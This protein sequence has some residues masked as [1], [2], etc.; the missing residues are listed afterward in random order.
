MHRRDFLL[1]SGTALASLFGRTAT[2]FSLPPVSGRL[3]T[4][5]GP[6]E[7]EAFGSALC[8]EHVLVDFI[9]AD[10]ITP[11]RYDANEVYQVALPY[12]RRAHELGCRGL[13]ECTPAYLGRDVRLLQRL[14]RESGLHLLTNT[15][16]YG[17]A[18]DQYVP[19]HAYDESAD[20]LASRWAA[21]WENGIEGTGIRPGFIKTGVD[22]GPL[23][24]IDRKLI[25]AAART[26]ARTGLAIASHTGDTRAALEQIEV[27]A[28][29]R[30]RHDAFIWVHAQNDWQAESRIEAARK[31]VWIEI[32]N[33]APP[34][35]A[36]CVARAVE[37]KARGLLGRLLVSHDAGWYSPGEPHGGQFRGFDA[38]YTALVPALRRAGFANDEVRRLLVSNPAEAFAVRPVR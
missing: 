2:A 32:D 21:E 16:Y 20:D 12:L 28:S 9:G 38:I 34:S 30:V 6:I 25:Q 13:V 31:G 10:T 36:E 1:A 26:H 5:L 24:A 27:L 11:E 3:M 8:H 18:K 4:V 35:V 7:P 19:R 33:V 23:S 14:S 22:A 15:G 29:E 37:L 17:A